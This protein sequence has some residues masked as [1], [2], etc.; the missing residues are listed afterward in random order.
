MP[1]QEISALPCLSEYLDLLGIDTVSKLPKGTKDLSEL[2]EEEEAEETITNT[3]NA[4]LF[5]LQDSPTLPPSPSSTTRS[6]SPSPSAAYPSLPSHINLGMADVPPP[7]SDLQR[8]VRRVHPETFYVTDA[9]NRCTWKVSSMEMRH[10]FQI[11]LQLRN[12]PDL[13]DRRWIPSSGYFDFANAYNTLVDDDTRFATYDSADPE[14]TDEIM[15]LESPS[16][17]MEGWGLEDFDLFGKEILLNGRISV[18]ESTHNQFQRMAS[19]Q[20]L[21][22]DRGRE[23]SIQKRSLKK[24]YQGAA[25]GGFNYVPDEFKQGA[26]KKR[27]RNADS[28]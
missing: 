27:R 22:A 18:P 2:Q 3:L 23:L 16:P 13:R 28:E 26:S 24:H 9:D 14:P 7:E 19:N 12:S 10:Y 4:L 11:D 20:A 15:F 17:S 6:L 21:R 5:L 8:H 25:A 1:Y